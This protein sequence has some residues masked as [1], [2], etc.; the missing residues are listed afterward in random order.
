MLLNYVLRKKYISYKYR[1]RELG[2]LSLRKRRLWG[3]FIANFQYLKGLRKKM[4][5]NSLLNQ[6]LTGQGGNG[7]TLKRGRFRLDVRRKFFRW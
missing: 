3:D 6:T 2:L 4:E 7:F 5:S 1:L